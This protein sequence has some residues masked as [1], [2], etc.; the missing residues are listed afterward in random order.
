MI[1]V[2]TKKDI[3]D[4]VSKWKQEGKSVGLVPTMGFFHEGHLSL[5][6]ESLRRTK[7]TVVSVFVNPTQFGPGED[8]EQYPRDLDR[9]L[10]LA[11]KVGVHVVFAPDV[12]EMYR[13]ATKTW[14]TVEGLS[15]NLCGRSRPGHFTGVATVVAKLFNIVQ[16]DV[17][18]FG[19]KDF[20]QLQIIRQMVKDLDFPIEIVGAPIYREPDGL[21]MSSR[22][23]YL[24]VE[25]RKIATCL[26]KALQKARELVISGKA[27]GPKELESVIEEYILNHPFT[28]IDYVFIG[29][30][31]T[32]VPKDELK[33]P[34]LIALAVFVGK[35]RL[36]DN[37]V[38][39]N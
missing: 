23:T 5:M 24:S 7:R 34:L 35:T 17:A 37:M 1:V 26:F 15:E 11:E 29:D 12:E 18:V 33:G 39:R 20:Q 30:P 9:D 4:M 21:A 6:K 10:H 38:I 36:I 22:N 19:E 28:K 27:K 8:F 13:D 16:P 25:E 32:L 3:R 31:D 2:K 14:V